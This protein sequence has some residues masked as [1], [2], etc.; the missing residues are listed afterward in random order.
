MSRLSLSLAAF[1]VTAAC[2]SAAEVPLVLPKAAQVHLPAGWKVHEVAYGDLN[3]DGRADLVFVR[4]G[5]DPDKIA[6]DPDNGGEFLNTNPRVLVVLIADKDGYRKQGD[7]PR[8]VPPGFVE[9]FG[10]YRDRYACLKVE[11]GILVV[12]FLWFP[13]VGSWWTSLDKFKFRLEADRMRLIGR[14]QDTFHRGSGE[15]TLVS[16]NYL[17]GKLQQT[18]GLNEFDEKESRP[19]VTWENLDSKKPI[20]LEDLPSCGRR[21]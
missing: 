17:S 7:Y 12:D 10:I 6:V 3:A 11:K 8:F 15:K 14:E 1:V 19:K 9:E 16:T 5:A 21:E 2:L 20:Y 18:S 13:M 4:E